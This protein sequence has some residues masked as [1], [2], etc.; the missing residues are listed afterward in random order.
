MAIYISEVGGP[1]GWCDLVRFRGK[2]DPPRGQVPVSCSYGLYPKNDFRC[3]S[4]VGRS[5]SVGATQTQHYSSAL[6]QG[7]LGLPH[8]QDKT[9]LSLIKSQRLRYIAYAEHDCTDLRKPDM[10]LHI[11]F[12]ESGGL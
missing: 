2:G 8:D 12:S 1:V 3:A 6:Q 9:Q 11:A 7:Q 5:M 4:D 10:L